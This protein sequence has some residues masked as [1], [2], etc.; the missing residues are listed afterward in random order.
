VEH[1][2]TI[3]DADGNYNKEYVD[4]TADFYLRLA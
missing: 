4:L 2:L 3:H 1:H